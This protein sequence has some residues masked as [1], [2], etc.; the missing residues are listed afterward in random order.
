MV[1]DGLGNVLPELACRGVVLD[2]LQ[3]PVRCVLQRGLAQ[4]A[5]NS[6]MAAESF[7]AA[8]NIA[9]PRVMVSAPILTGKSDA[10][11][12]G[13]RG[14]LGRATRA[15]RSHHHFS[16]DDDSSDILPLFRKSSLTTEA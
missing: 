6:A 14:G 15:G 16:Y 8:A 3:R 12:R 2:V 7:A 13:A 10:M 9:A 1:N 5:S 4:P 11:L